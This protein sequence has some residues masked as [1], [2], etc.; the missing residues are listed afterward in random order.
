MHPIGESMD[1]TVNDVGNESD[2]SISF[3]AVQME[4]EHNLFS[5]PRK[6]AEIHVHDVK[7]IW[8]RDSNSTYHMCR[9]RVA[10]VGF[11]LVDLT[12][13][14]EGRLPDTENSNPSRPFVYI[15]STCKLRVA[16]HR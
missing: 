5:K 15:G 7:P 10:W 16:R 12:S 6:A 11:D 2:H 8:T 1:S 9:S 13:G 3:T 4:R 14:L